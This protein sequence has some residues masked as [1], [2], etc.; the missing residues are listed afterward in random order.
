MQRD[1]A[2]RFCCWLLGVE[3]EREREREESNVESLYCVGRYPRNENQTRSGDSSSST[4]RKSDGDWARLEAF[5]ETR[6]ADFLYARIPL[7]KSRRYF[8]YY[9][10]FVRNNMM[11]HV[12]IRKDG[13]VS[14]L[15]IYEL[16]K[17]GR[18]D[19]QDCTLNETT[20]SNR[21]TE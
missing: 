4:S 15:K 7:P 8:R 2:A 11:Q 19:L 17:Y 18:F 5:A 9:S 12:S 10:T 13:F 14:F 16:Y 21:Y 3:V 1:S 20:G 6:V